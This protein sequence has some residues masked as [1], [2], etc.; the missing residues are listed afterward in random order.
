V[1]EF[2][3]GQAVREAPVGPVVLAAVSVVQAAGV[4]AVPAALVCR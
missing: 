3:A 4:P 2:R 1:V